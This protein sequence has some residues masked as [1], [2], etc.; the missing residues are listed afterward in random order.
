MSNAKPPAGRGKP[1]YAVP[2]G[3]RSA[4]CANGGRSEIS[5]FESK[6]KRA[7]RKARLFLSI[8]Q[9]AVDQKV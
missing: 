4:A 9:V 1:L 3:A 8:R 2:L 5:P 7:G 6:R